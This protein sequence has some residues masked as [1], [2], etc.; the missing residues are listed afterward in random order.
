MEYTTDK[1]GKTLLL[2][3]KTDYQVMM[4]WEKPYM[5]ALIDYLNPTGDVLEIGFG[6]GYSANRIQSFNIK[7]HTIIESDPVVLEKLKK[8]ATRQKHPVHIVP[9][10]WQEQI[11]NLGKFD[12]IFFDDSPSEKF[13]DPGNVR[14]YYFYYKMLENHVNKDCRLSWYCSLPIYWICHPDT[15]FNMETF[16]IEVPDNADYVQ[17][18]SKNNKTLYMPLI[19]FKNGCS[20]NI[21]PIFLNQDLVFGFF[22]N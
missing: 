2:D 8:W 10:D 11:F 18:I 1:Y 7:S 14:F 6:L 9:G 17:D 16:K 20:D 5:E 15:N 22:G 19:T 3:K 4:E 21:N 13:P 12:S